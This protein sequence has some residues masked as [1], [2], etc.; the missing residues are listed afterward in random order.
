MPSRAPR[1]CRCG[2]LQPCPTHQR[3]PW[4]HSASRHARGYGSA[5]D[6]QRRVVLDRD[7]YTCGYCGEH[8]TTV[9]HRKPKAEGG[10]DDPGNLVACCVVCQQ[11]KA[12]HEGQRAQAK[13][14]RL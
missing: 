3:R 14:A 7:R 9:D 8:A 1:A 13:R 10:T 2:R 11:R 12:G 4:A 5:W 6:R